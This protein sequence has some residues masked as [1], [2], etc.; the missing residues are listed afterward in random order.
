VD[1]KRELEKEPVDQELSK[2]R[3]FNEENKAFATKIQT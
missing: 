1:N 2:R 3:S